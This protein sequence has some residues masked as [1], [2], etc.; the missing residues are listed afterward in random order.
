M[1][2]VLLDEIVMTDY[3]QFEIRWAGDGWDGDADIAFASQENGLVGAAGSGYVYINLARRSGGSSVRIELS[4]VDPGDDQTWQDCIEVSIAIPEGAE[5]VW[6][7]WG[8]ESGGRLELPAN[9]YRLRV[10]ARDREIGREGEFAEDVVDFY[11]LQFWPADQEPDRI[12]RVGGPEAEYWH[13]AWG[14]RR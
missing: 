3:G 7:S 8:G 4:D 14:R 13:S 12:V 9:A 10:I 2:D 1:V 6:E 5:P 11:R